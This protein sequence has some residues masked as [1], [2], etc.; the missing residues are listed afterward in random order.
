M[1]NARHC[2]ATNTPIQAW[3]MLRIVAP[4]SRQQAGQTLCIVTV[5]SVQNNERWT[6]TQGKL[7][8]ASLGPSAV[9]GPPTEEKEGEGA[10]DAKRAR[11]EPEQDMSG[12][13]AVLPCG[14]TPSSSTSIPI[15]SGASSRST[16]SEREYRS[17]EFS[18]CLV[19]Q[20][21]ETCTR[22]QHCE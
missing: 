9:P 1:P 10:Q 8:R 16:Y 20:R 6:S 3:H 13:I 21:C 17:A 4:G 2:L 22:R 7:K 11:G 15:S 18:E 5:L 19:R 12:E 14:A